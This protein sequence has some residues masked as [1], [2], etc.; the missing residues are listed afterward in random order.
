[1]EAATGDLN[2]RVALV[3]GDKVDLK[4]LLPGGLIGAGAPA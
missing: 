4:L 2:R 3:T 1:M